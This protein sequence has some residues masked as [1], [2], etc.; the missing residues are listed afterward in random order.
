MDQPQEEKKE[1]TTKY[2]YIID[3]TSTLPVESLGA[4]LDEAF[5][6]VKDI[7]GV[8]LLQATLNPIPEGI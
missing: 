6:Q 7:E 5:I 3:F 4:V 8:R 1:Q 2:S